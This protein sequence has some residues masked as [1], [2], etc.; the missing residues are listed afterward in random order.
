MDQ[1]EKMIFKRSCDD[2]SQEASNAFKV[3]PIQQI[4]MESSSDIERQILNT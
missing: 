4:Y 1:D 2:I 3:N